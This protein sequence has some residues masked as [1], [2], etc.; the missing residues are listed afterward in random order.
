MYVK[1]EIADSSQSHRNESWAESTMTDFVIIKQRKQRTVYEVEVENKSIKS[2]IWVHSLLLSQ[3]EWICFSLNKTITMQIRCNLYINKNLWLER[4]VQ[5]D[6]AF[7]NN[8]SS[9][10]TSFIRHLVSTE[11]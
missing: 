6:G 3:S 5:S 7:I 8:Y 4:V 9:K 1:F 2:T 11:S 10:P